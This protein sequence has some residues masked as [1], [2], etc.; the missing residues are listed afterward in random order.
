LEGT[1]Q[2][3]VVAFKIVAQQEHDIIFQKVAP[4]SLLNERLANFKSS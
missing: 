1:A 2:L 3:S 4:H